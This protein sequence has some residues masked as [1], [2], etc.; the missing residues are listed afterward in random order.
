MNNL[1][2]FKGI[3]N[4]S[5]SV[6]DDNIKITKI[7]IPI[8]QRDYAQGRLDPDVKR[9]RRR[10]LDALYNAITV[11]PIT[12]DFIY[13]DISSEGVLTPLDGQQRLTTLYLLYW[14]AAKIDK[15]EKADYEFLKKFSY[16][17]RYS[18]R[19]FCE[20]LVDFNPSFSQDTI[21]E[22]IINQYWFPLE[23]KKDPTISSMLVMLDDINDKFNSLNNLWQKID[24]SVKFYFLP[25]HNMGLTDEL[26]IKMNSR[27]KP[28]T[29]FEN[30]KSELEYELKKS[31]FI[32]YISLINKIDREW[33]DLL[34]QYKDENNSIDNAFLHYFGFICDVICY[35]NGDTPFRKNLDE[36][37]LIKEYF[38]ANNKDLNRNVEILES[39]FDCWDLISKKIGI[40]NF[41]NKFLSYSHK[42]GKI[43]VD[44]R[45][46]I[47]IFEDVL[48]NFGTMIGNTYRRYFPLSRFILLYAF[49]TYCI[50]IEKIDEK[51]FRRRIR[52]VNNLINNSEYEISN[53][54]NRTGGNRIPAIL[55][56]VDSII[57]NGVI[58]DELE[59]NF[60][61]KQLIEEQ[62]KLEWTIKNP[63]KANTLYQ[64]EDNE[65]L[66]G[67]ISVVGIE[68]SDLFET[69]ELLFECEY[70]KIDK[71][72]LTIDNYAVNENNWRY[73]LGSGGKNSFKN[74]FHSS[75]KRFENLKKTL[76][77]LLMLNKK[78]DNNFL[79]SLITNYLSDCEK[80]SC[81]DWRYYY[82]K[83]DE[84]R[85]NRYGKYCW[86][87]LLERPYEF[88]VIW[89]QYNLSENAYNPFLK[90]VDIHNRLSR[91]DFGRKIID[92][93]KYIV[94]K[95]DS[96]M[97]YSLENNTLM[98]KIN[99]NQNKYGI[100][101][102]DRIIKMK[103]YLRNLDK[104]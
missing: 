96:Y 18:A 2:S 74:L 63:E 61:S 5:F 11:K 78:P 88:D 55:K 97:I 24:E 10:F 82:I 34:W 99:I 22:E 45:Y 19:N 13:G 1:Y 53:S 75:S 21:S 29:A 92:S 87:A 56:Q 101:T 28:L 20:K 38:S 35:K 79:D 42:E 76:N 54:E 16:E 31:V 52:I 32:D 94:S 23:W 86:N 95:N 46:Q 83:Y 64:L 93:D 15:I 36:I 98:E 14:Y 57:L 30:F 3:F 6:G 80:N 8:I 37:D 50:N 44:T 40:E 62:E 9:I 7:V 59:N 58:D 100:D 84:F 102:E 25:I 81:F 4:S 89:G 70:D 104:F 69:F 65:L 26:Y 73:Q 68:N 66:Y 85:P 12:L 33:T 91:E 71:A 77:T 43:I 41:L 90:A 47:N 39:Y 67:Q 27:G 60:N 51:D 103:E 49:I 48:H 17:T 72:L